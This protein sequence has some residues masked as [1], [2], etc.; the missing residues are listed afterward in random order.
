MKR[1]LLSGYEMTDSVGGPQSRGVP[2]IC[3]RVIVKANLKTKHNQPDSGAALTKSKQPVSRHVIIP[4]LFILQAFI[5]HLL[6]SNHCV[7]LRIEL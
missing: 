7:G 4:T 3:W 1:L 5:E 6:C 2:I